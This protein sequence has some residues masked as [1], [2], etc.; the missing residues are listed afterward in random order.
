MRVEAALS[1]SGFPAS[2]F[3]NDPTYSREGSPTS[4]NFSLLDVNKV[5]NAPVDNEKAGSMIRPYTMESNEYSVHT[6]S[7]ETSSNGSKTPGVTT[8]P[9][10]G[11]TSVAIIKA[12]KKDG[13]MPMPKG[14]VKSESRTG[15]DG[16]KSTIFTRDR[17]DS[18]IQ[19]PPVAYLQAPPN[20]TRSRKETPSLLTQ[21]TGT[22]THS[23]SQAVITVARKSPFVSATPRTLLMNTM[24]SKDASSPGKNPTLREART[25]TDSMAGVNISMVPQRRPNLVTTVNNTLGMTQFVAPADWETTGGTGQDMP[26]WVN[27]P[28]QPD[29]HGMI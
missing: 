18:W 9:P 11:D 16:P 6:L 13:V 23:Y 2:Y 8:L 14:S 26:A 12:L 20:E 4:F 1:S 10:P 19:P 15:R 17:E 5:R 3:T 27:F 24:S 21:A 25:S 29:N 7:F 22:S 28:P